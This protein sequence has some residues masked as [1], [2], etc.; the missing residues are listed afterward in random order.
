MTIVVE[1]AELETFC[2]LD[3]C[4]LFTFPLLSATLAG[5]STTYMEDLGFTSNSNRILGYNATFPEKNEP[6]VSH[7]H[8]PPE[9]KVGRCVVR[10]SSGRGK[11]KA[12][13]SGW[14]KPLGGGRSDGTWRPTRNS[15]GCRPVVHCA[16]GGAQS[17]TL[18]IH[19][20]FLF[21]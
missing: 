8:K 19:V 1:D 6:K 21:C 3:G 16:G 11:A 4:R 12:Y 2:Q 15:R 9:E 17:Q 7:T 5:G 20:H 13:F 18:A 10:A 14:Q